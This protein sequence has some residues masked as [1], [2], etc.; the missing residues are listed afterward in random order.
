LPLG[1]EATAAQ[2]FFGG[3]DSVGPSITPTR[4]TLALPAGLACLC[5][6]IRHCRRDEVSLDEV[7]RIVI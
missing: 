3:D 5:G 1:S 2:I 4:I 7:E 6:P